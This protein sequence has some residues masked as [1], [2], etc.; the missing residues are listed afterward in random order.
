MFRGT[1]FQTD[2]LTKLSGERVREEGAHWHGGATLHGVR[3]A[4]GTHFNVEQVGAVMF[5]C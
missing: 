4:R 2:S 5:L 3:C 1:T